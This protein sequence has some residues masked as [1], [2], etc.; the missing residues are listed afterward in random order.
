METDAQERANTMSLDS[1]MV[2]RSCMVEFRAGHICGDEQFNTISV[3]AR[4]RILFD[5][6]A[7]L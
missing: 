6:C 3:G 5:C 7:H 2:G 4:S 1:F